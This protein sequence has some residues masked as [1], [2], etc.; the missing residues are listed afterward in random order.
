MEKELEETIFQIITQK[1]KGSQMIFPNKT[2]KNIIIKK[3][4]IMKLIRKSIKESH[5]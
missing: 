5:G 4:D 2:N 1:W 3:E